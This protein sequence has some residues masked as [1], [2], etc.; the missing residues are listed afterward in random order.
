M[1]F[2]PE[3]PLSGIGFTDFMP[4]VWYK[5]KLRRT[6]GLARPPH[7]AELRGGRLP[8]DGLGQ[9]QA[10]GPHE[11]GYTPFALDITGLLAPG[12]NVVVVRAR[13]DVRSG[14]QPTGK[15]SKRFASYDCVYRRT[16]GIWQT[17]WLEPVPDV[18]I[19]RTKATADVDNGEA[20]LHV[21]FNAVPG[22]GSVTAKVSF[23]GRPVAVQTKR[24]EKVVRFTVPIKERR[25]LGRPRP[26]PLRRRI[27]L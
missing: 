22:A 6:R 10:G 17:V 2:A 11:G 8:D 14:R 24:A 5:R 26:Q 25:A 15:Q 9:R 3:S 7:P 18:G 12:D 19:E 1:P 27:R 23:Q 4:A 20:N 16:T 13:D 21:Y